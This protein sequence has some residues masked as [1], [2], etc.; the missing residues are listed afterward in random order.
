MAN[1]VLILH[2]WSDSAK[3]FEPLKDWL[4]ARGRPSK[5]V[6]LGN[7]ES[8]EDHVT[9][10]DLADGLQT[11]LEEMVKAGEITLAPFSLDVIVHSTGAPV[12]GTGCATTSRPSAGAIWPPVPSPG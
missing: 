6:F 9:F 11:R 8:M 12:I 2:G 1:P 5:D 4:V 3:S 7:Y 10:D